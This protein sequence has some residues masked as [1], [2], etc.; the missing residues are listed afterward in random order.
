MLNKY[1]KQIKIIN[2]DNKIKA[3]LKWEEVLNRLHLQ[4]EIVHLSKVQ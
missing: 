3:P 2:I 1:N 4:K